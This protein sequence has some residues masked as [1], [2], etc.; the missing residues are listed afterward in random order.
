VGYFNLRKGKPMSLATQLTPAYVGQS[1]EY[2]NAIEKSCVDY[3]DR[4]YELDEF[5]VI[6]R[7]RRL[8]SAVPPLDALPQ[9][10]NASMGF[11]AYYAIRAIEARD[12]TPYAFTL[13]L[14]A[15]DE[16]L[17]VDA[18]TRDAL[19]YYSATCG[20]AVDVFGT[21]LPLIMLAKAMPDVGR[22]VLQ[23]CVGLENDTQ[24][25]AF[26]Y[27]LRSPV[28]GEVSDSFPIRLVRDRVEW[29]PSTATSGWTRIAKSLSGK[30]CLVSTRELMGAARTIYRRDVSAAQKLRPNRNAQR[31]SRSAVAMH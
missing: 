12:L 31:G 5:S 27:V 26:S 4:L 13:T 24:L 19:R 16:N 20:K 9:W 6:P 10:R 2:R 11:R 21:P 14:K 25:S 3:F 28:N 22:I 23:C 30:S 1:T 7:R 8:P 15:K 29:I 18:Y 17:H